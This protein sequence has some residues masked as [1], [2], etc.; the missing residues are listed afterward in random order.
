MLAV[1]VAALLAGA[2]AA[3]AGAHEDPPGC[4]TGSFNPSFAE[5][6]SGLGIVH[7]NG[8][9][10]NLTV[11]VRNDSPGACTVDDATL[12]VQLPAPNGTATGPLVTVATDF[13]GAGGMGPTT[14]PTTVPYEVELDPG[15]FRAPMTV[16]YSGTFHG[17]TDTP[18]GGSLTTFLVISRPQIEVSVTPSV[19]SGPAP[20]TVTYTYEA[21]NTSPSPPP[22]PPDLGPAPS[23]VASVGAANERAMI[24]DDTCSE[25]AYLSG[26][27]LI[28]T[29]AL[30]DPTETWTFTCTRT[31]EAPGTFAN[32]ARMVG[33]ST[34][35]GRPWPATTAGTAVTALGADLTVAKSHAGNFVSGDAGAYELLVRNA[36]N[37]ATAGQVTVEDQ[38]PAGL[39]ATAIA[40]PGWSCELATLRCV[41]S[42]PLGGGDSYPGVRVEVTAGPPA[43]VTNRVTVSGGGDAFAGN[44]FAEDPTA[45]VAPPSNEFEIRRVKSNPDGT[46]SLRVWVAGKGLLS[47]DDPIPP[48]KTLRPTKNLVKRVFASAAASRVVTLKLKPARAAKQRLRENGKAAARVRVTFTPEGG[49]AASK[50]R[51]IVFKL[52]ARR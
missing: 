10:L 7:R 49:T 6:A 29:P 12:S 18:V 48:G 40:G 19:T 46:V 51:R 35:D 23:L 44:N 47:A 34:R 20:L 8:D 14:L 39:T 24:A 27:T 28:T 3:L 22:P 36:G 37:E 41:R 26:D 52:P 38:L 33:S 2:L 43:Q 13:T 50:A 5:P 9:R 11:S 1:G 31:F 4:T 30:L 25:V 17:A 32:A 21:T 42:D 15:V 45:I 16:S